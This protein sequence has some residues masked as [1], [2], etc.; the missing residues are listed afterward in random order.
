MDESNKNKLKIFKIV[1]Y[2][3]KRIYTTIKFT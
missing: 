2:I 3:N 1:T